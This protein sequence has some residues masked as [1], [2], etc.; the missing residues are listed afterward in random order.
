MSALYTERIAA[1]DD[2]SG[3]IPAR[4][5]LSFVEQSDWI[6]CSV[7]VV[8][9]S[10]LC[11]LVVVLVLGT[12]L[13]A[14]YGAAKSAV[15]AESC[16]TTWHPGVSLVFPPETQSGVLSGSGTGE[17]H[18]RENRGDSEVPVDKRNCRMVPYLAKPRSPD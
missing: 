5:I 15:Y 9:A 12:I 16:W 13:A 14:F 3:A 11:G 18:P 2:S 17:D 8:D 4:Q 7:S 1:E 6:V 10:V